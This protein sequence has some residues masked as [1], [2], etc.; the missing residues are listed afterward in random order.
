M[1]SLGASRNP[2]STWLS[3][4]RASM[5]ASACSRTTSWVSPGTT[6]RSTMRFADSGTERVW[7]PP[8]MRRGQTEPSP[9]FGWESTSRSASALAVLVADDRPV[10]AAVVHPHRFVRDE[11]PGDERV[12]DAVLEVVLDDDAPGRAPRVLVTSR[13]AGCSTPQTSSVSG[14]ASMRSRSASSSSVESAY[15]VN[16]PWARPSTSWTPWPSKPPAPASVT[17]SV[18]QSGCQMSSV[19]RDPGSSPVGT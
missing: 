3:M 9:S 19:S 6:W 12:V 14:D 18:Q 2:T 13:C 10:L 17:W 1:S 11:P 16:R 8:S 15:A 5:A 7:L 4:S